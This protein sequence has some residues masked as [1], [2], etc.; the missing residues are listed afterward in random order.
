[1]THDIPAIAGLAGGHWSLPPRGWSYADGALTIDAGPQTDLFID[2]QGAPPTL[3]AAA[4]RYA[5]PDGDWMLSATVQVGFGA[6]YDAGVL[7]IWAG[8]Q[9]WGKLC[10]EYS[11]QAEPMVV[12]V[13]TR[14]VSDDANAFTVAGDTVALRLTRIGSAFA[15]HASVA[16]GAWQ[17]IRHFGLPSAGPLMVGF[18]SQSPTGPGCRSRFSAIALRRE[19]LADLRSG[20]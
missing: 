3:N 7:L 12:S 8:D 15:F 18:V 4:L 13:V 5:A 6:T 10:F 2:P 11:P 1:M 17:L 14:G 19:R 16:G 9:V 20:E